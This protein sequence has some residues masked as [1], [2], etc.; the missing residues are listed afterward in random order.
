MVSDSTRDAV[1]D[2]LDG[3]RPDLPRMAESRESDDEL[4]ARSETPAVSTSPEPQTSSVEPEP[5]AEPIADSTEI[6]PASNVQ[7]S[8][9]A[10]T[11]DDYLSTCK[12]YTPAKKTF[13][14]N[15]CYRHTTTM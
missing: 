14:V 2:R 9:R 8:P 11:A 12:L 15:Y 10:H 6:I 4:E 5:L 1:L 13:R 3:V 7:A